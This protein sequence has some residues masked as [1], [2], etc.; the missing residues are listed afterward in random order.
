MTPLPESGQ[1][2]S[3][4][5]APA[6]PSR[7][8][9]STTRRAAEG[10]GERRRAPTHLPWSEHPGT[11]GSGWRNRR[12]GF[13]RVQPRR[14]ALCRHRSRDLARRPSLCR[15]ARCFEIVR[16]PLLRRVIATPMRLVGVLV[17]LDHCQCC[18]KP[19]V[20]HDLARFHGL[21]L[22]RS[23][24]NSTSRRCVWRS[25]TS[26]PWCSTR[27]H[28]R[29]LWIRCPRDTSP[30][31]C[32]CCRSAAISEGDSPAVARSAASANFAASRTVA[33]FGVPF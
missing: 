31:R 11:L 30:A 32:S 5:E 18:A 1:L 4:V 20:L 14:H 28:R 29:S 8:D 17:L 33:L 7:P 9:N 27:W 21:D 10:M 26:S 6:F 15:L 25:P 13:V 19:L 24:R 2:S 12:R 22:I 23:A 3:S 16:W